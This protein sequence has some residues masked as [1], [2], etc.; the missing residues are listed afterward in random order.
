MVALLLS[1]CEQDDSSLQ[2]NADFTAFGVSFQVEDATLTFANQEDF[3]QLYDRA[4]VNT[5]EAADHFAAAIKEAMDRS[6]FTSLHPHLE[7]TELSEAQ[8]ADYVRVIRKRKELIEGVYD[9]ELSDED[10]EFA[11]FIAD[12]TL[13][14][15][16][17][18]D[19]DIRIG[20]FTYHYTP[21]G[22]FV[23]T[24]ES[25]EEAF[26]AVMQSASSVKTFV[27]DHHSAKGSLIPVAPGLQHYVADVTPFNDI[28]GVEELAPV[29][30]AAKDLDELSLDMCGGQNNTTVWTSVFGPSADCTDE[31]ASNRRIKTKIW[32]QNYLLF[33]SLGTNVRSQRRRVG[34]WWASQV[35][36]LELG[37]GFF[38]YEFTLPDP[39]APPS[40]FG[41]GRG[42]LAVRY[43]DGTTIGF[44]GQILQ[45][46]PVF[47]RTRSIA[48][49]LPFLPVV[50]PDWIEARVFIK[51]GGITI[52]QEFRASDY[53]NFRRIVDDFIED[54][55]PNFLRNVGNIPDQ[56]EFIQVDARRMQVMA[57][58]LNRNR[59]NIANMKHYFDFNT[60]QVGISG[61]PSIPGGLSLDLSD[62]MNAYDYDQVRGLVYGAGRRGSTVRGNWVGMSQD[63]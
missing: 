62:I 33:A 54:E 59:R 7:D 44:N 11:E 57:D 40:Q 45:S 35:D 51:L 9:V 25:G 37:T 38:N 31:F 21:F 48:A 16:L 10:L 8:V 49:N 55:V 24:S 17:N 63:N 29:T 52:N 43:D 18:K 14:S 60:G 19:G 50:D 26:R 39:P 41:G 6:A 34:V 13:A 32:D 28:K 4:V 27:Q 53:L 3:S 2:P 1:G 58:I 42:I 47:N 61:N 46:G 36:E 20:T 56:V 23:A 30:N 5:D 12:P 22:L 15:L